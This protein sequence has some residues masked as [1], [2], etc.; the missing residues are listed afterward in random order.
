MELFFSAWHLSLSSSESSRAGSDESSSPSPKENAHLHAKFCMFFHMFLKCHL[1]DEFIP[2]TL[3]PNL[4]LVIEGILKYYFFKKIKHSQTVS[5]SF[6][7]ASCSCAITIL[8]HPRNCFRGQA[9]FVRIWGQS[10]LIP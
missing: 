2:S 6:R 9:A 4:L 1:N 5:C 8:Q 10:W 7:E 3:P